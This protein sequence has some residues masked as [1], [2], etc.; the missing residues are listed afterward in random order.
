MKTLPKTYLKY[1]TP[2]MCLMPHFIFSYNNIIGNR[3][4]LNRFH[5]KYAETSDYKMSEIDEYTS[6]NLNFFNL[7]KESDF[8]FYTSSSLSTSSD[9]IFNRAPR[10]NRGYITTAYENLGDKI[11]K[12]TMNMFSLK[13]FFPTEKISSIM[14][15]LFS[16]DKDINEFVDALIKRNTKRA[17]KLFSD[18]ENK[19]HSKINW[20][21]QNPGTQLS[22]SFNP[23]MEDESKWYGNYYS[24]FR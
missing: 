18:L 13:T 8:Y 7:I 4:V 3:I 20:I 6:I 21:T 12:R 15:K 22:G 19:D 24:P 10:I 16:D 1:A 23:I 2:E 9:D 5:N 11:K 17:L 14:E